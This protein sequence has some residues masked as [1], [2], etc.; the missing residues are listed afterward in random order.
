M[1]HL[2]EKLMKVSESVGDIRVVG[3]ASDDGNHEYIV[4]TSDFDSPGETWAIKAYNL[5]VIYDETIQDTL[6]SVF[7]REHTLRRE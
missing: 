5:K 3:L 4:F 2:Y 1:E 6:P 7:P